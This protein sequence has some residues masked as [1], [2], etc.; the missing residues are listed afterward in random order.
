MAAFPSE[1]PTDQMVQICQLRAGH[2][3]V[4]PRKRPHVRRRRP[5]AVG[6]GGCRALGC[7][8]RIRAGSKTPCAQPAAGAASE[9][10]L[11]IAPIQVMQP[12]V[13]GQR[14]GR[15]V[16]DAVDGEALQ[17][18]ADPIQVLGRRDGLR[19]GLKIGVSAQG[20]G[21]PGR[22]ETPPAGGGCPNAPS[23]RRQGQSGQQPPARCRGPPAGLCRQADAAQLLQWPR[24]HHRRALA[25]WERTCNACL[26]PRD[27][28]ILTAAPR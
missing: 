1:K 13:A 6:R 19:L 14:P 20:P 5:M 2:R 3:D 28:S 9:G 21:H 23:Q 4:R 25:D 18:L 16:W 22:R 10:G 26:G 11:T 8:R 7:A 24:F 12:R 15:C 27:C 17:Q